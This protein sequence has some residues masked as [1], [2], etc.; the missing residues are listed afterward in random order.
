MCVLRARG[1]SLLHGVRLMDLRLNNLRGVRGNEGGEGYRCA[2]CKCWPT[3]R[4]EHLSARVQWTTALRPALSEAQLM[5][6]LK[7]VTSLIAT[8]LFYYIWFVA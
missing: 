6:G 1:D 7:I 4:H 2:I 8:V 5:L 3:L